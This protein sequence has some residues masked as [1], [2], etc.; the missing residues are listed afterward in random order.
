MSYTQRVGVLLAQPTTIESQSLTKRVGKVMLEYTFSVKL[1]GLVSASIAARKS[2]RV[3]SLSTCVD[4]IV[5]VDTALSAAAPTV[6]LVISINQYERRAV[7][8]AENEGVVVTRLPNVVVVDPTRCQSTAVN[9][10]TLLV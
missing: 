2:P 6:P 4:V 1:D 5:H 7:G 3:R 9:V 10:A 8:F